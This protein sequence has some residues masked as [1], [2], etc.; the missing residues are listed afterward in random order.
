[1]ISIVFNHLKLVIEKSTC[2]RTV[3]WF[4][5]LFLFF[6]F[7][8]DCFIYSVLIAMHRVVN[9]HIAKSIP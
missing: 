9:Y 1:M 6:G 3:A 7:F 2:V 8:C 4:S 5:F